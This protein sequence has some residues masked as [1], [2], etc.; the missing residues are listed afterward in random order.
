MFMDNNMKWL[1]ESRSKR[2]VEALQ[3]NRFDACYVQ[4]KEEACAKALEMIPEGASV[5]FGG[6]MTLFEIG[7]VA[8]LKNNPRW[9][10]I[11]RYG[12]NLSPEQL[13]EIFLQALRVDY[14]LTSANAVSEDGQLFFVDGANTRVAPVLFGP[15]HV[16]LVLGVNKICVDAAAAHQ[17]MQIVSRPVNCKRLNTQTPCVAMG[18]CQDCNSPARICNSTV[19]LHK[20]NI[21]SDHHQIHVI[22]VGEELGY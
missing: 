4:N 10:L 3:R 8:A 13:R 20:H 11:D 22:M 19:V 9:N 16:I 18:A 7:L 17:Y 15:A 21:R 14:F 2:V 5:A 6:S 1:H 12:L